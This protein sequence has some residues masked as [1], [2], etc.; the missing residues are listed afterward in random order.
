MARRR[1][2]TEDIMAD[3]A[4]ELEKDQDVQQEESETPKAEHH[5]ARKTSGPAPTDAEHSEG[6]SSE[7]I[8]LDT[9][10]GPIDEAMTFIGESDIVDLYPAEKSGDY[11]D[12]KGKKRPAWIILEFE[13]MPKL[14]PFA[15]KNLKPTTGL[16][17]LNTQTG[18]LID[19]NDT[20]KGTKYVDDPD[21]ME[22]INNLVEYAFSKYGVHSF[23]DMDIIDQML[24]NENSKI[25]ASVYQGTMKSTL[26][27]GNEN[28]R[29]YFSLINRHKSGNFIE[30][31]RVDQALWQAGAAQ[32]DGNLTVNVL[33]VVNNDKRYERENN[34]GSINIFQFYRF[35]VYFEYN[36]KNYQ[37]NYRY[38]R[39]KDADG[40]DIPAAQR[41]PNYELMVAR[42]SQIADGLNIQGSDIAD[43]IAKVHDIPAKVHVTES[44]VRYNHGPLKGEKVYYAK[45]VANK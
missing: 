29:S 9:K 43:A 23:E 41:E 40:N 22:K 12:S 17:N 15:P 18:E 20:K 11:I 27:N 32:P 42:I 6:K 26:D 37:I 34:D 4:D 25:T 31:E 14:G 39:S 36:G 13:Y 38:N 5:R 2:S 1:N 28:Y 45:L 3:M 10:F 8:E 21:R 19:P 16:I 7:E 33:K 24:N 30:T 44:N 35:E